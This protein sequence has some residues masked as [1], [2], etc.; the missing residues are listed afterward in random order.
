MRCSLPPLH[1]SPLVAVLLS[2]VNSS[3]LRGGWGG[4]GPTLN[5]QGPPDP[6]IHIFCGL[7][8]R[9]GI[10]EASWGRCASD[11]AGDAA[12]GAMTTCF[13][14]FLVFWACHGHHFLKKWIPDETSGHAGRLKMMAYGSSSYDLF[15]QNI[16]LTCKLQSTFRILSKT[17]FSFRAI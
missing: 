9:G 17:V 11:G 15:G 2:L 8:G 7:R 10:P 12:N 6:Q 13:G 16:D 3:L 5:K 4:G 1:R 14:R